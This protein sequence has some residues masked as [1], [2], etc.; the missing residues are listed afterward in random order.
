MPK[1]K[2]LLHVCCAPCAT[3]PIEELDSDASLFFYNPNID[4]D[5]EYEKRMEEIKKLA[6][7]KNKSLQIGSY[8][9]EK[10]QKATKGH[11]NDPEGRERCKICYKLRLEQ[12]AKTAK[13]QNYQMFATSL[14]TSPYKN[15]E[16]INKIGKELA[17]KYGLQYLESDF[18]KNG[19]YKK[20]IESSKSL[21]LYRQKYCGC[22]CSRNYLTKKLS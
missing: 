21:G 1:T 12:T 9:K 13:K 8:D 3:V 11:E 6:K 16:T 14:T 15:K 2:L 10:W 22:S 18:K 7:I 19:G 20:S 17:D 4:V 5:E